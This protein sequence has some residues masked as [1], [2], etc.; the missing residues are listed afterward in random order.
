MADLSTHYKERTPE[1]TVQIVKDFFNNNGLTLI[2]SDLN[3]SEAGTWYCHVECY[4]NKIRLGG[5]NGKGVNKE[6]ALASGYAELYERFCNQMWF[7]FSPYWGDFYQEQS[8]K[9]NKYYYRPDEKKLTVNELINNCKRIQQYFDIFSCSDEE[10]IKEMI[11]LILG[12]H[13]TY[14]GMPIYNIADT[15]DKLYIEPR[16]LAR[17]SRS[18]GMAAGNTIDEALVQGISELVER[19]ATQRFFQDFGATHYALNLNNIDNLEIQE[20]INKIKAL[21]YDFYVFDLSYNYDIPVVMSLLIDKQ[22]GTIN[23][24]LGAFPVFDIAIERVITELYQGIKTYR[25]NAIQGRLQRPFK[26]VSYREMLITYGNSFS[27]EIFSLNFFNSIQYVDEYNKKVFQDKKL[28]NKELVEYYA[29]LAK[30]H[31]VKYYYM[32]NS[33]SAS[34]KAIYIIEEFAYIDDNFDTTLTSINL[35]WNEYSKEKLL[36]IMKQYEKFYESM[37]LF[38]PVDMLNLINII[39]E[40]QNYDDSLNAFFDNVMLWHYIL[41]TTHS[42]NFSL[43]GIFLQPISICVDNVS[44]EFINSEIYFEQKKYLQLL[45]YI[46]TDLYTEVELLQIFNKI[47]GY[48]ITTEDLNNCMSVNYL[49]K[50]SYIEPL[51]EFLKKDY[52]EIIDI[53]V[54]NSNPS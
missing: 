37:K 15:N 26:S 33:L 2:E 11:K 9:K 14:I 6:Y 41:G 20:K 45:R 46:N 49:I 32:D 40:S 16:L 8:F 48:N 29:E 23:F 43:L 22:N 4:K 19:E 24:N 54:T 31:N 30:N 25:Q 44:F 12:E 38:Q 52:R 5:A 42:A 17:V 27:G 39:K 10:I 28:T 53:F 21:G 18:N 7:I 50:K 36:N 35:Q 13:E 51:Q 1:E 34:M 47:F 3:E